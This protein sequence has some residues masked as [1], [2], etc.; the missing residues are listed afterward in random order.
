MAGRGPAPKDP[1]KRI[2]RNADSVGTT[3]IEFVQGEQPELPEGVNWPQPTV[4]WWEAWGNSPLADQFTDLDWSFLLDT[5]LL[6]A[7]MWSGDK[8]AAAEL[9]LRVAKFGQTPEDRARLRIQFANAD[10]ADNKADRHRRTTQPDDDYE[11]LAPNI[12]AM[13]GN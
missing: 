7:A 2:R 3:T 1:K 5:A 6:H 11:D 8:G 13:P 4:A 9:R 12:V 10:E